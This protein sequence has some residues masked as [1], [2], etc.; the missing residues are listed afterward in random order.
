MMKS[1]RGNAAGD[2]IANHLYV[3]G[4][5]FGKALRTAECFDPALSRWKKLPPMQQAREKPILCV[6]NHSLY[7]SGGCIPQQST[8]ETTFIRHQLELCTVERFN[9]SCQC[10]E[11]MP[12]M[13]RPC[14]HDVGAV[15]GVF[16]GS[17]YVFGA[18]NHHNLG[19]LLHS[20]KYTFQVFNTTTYRWTEIMQK[21]FLRAHV[22]AKFTGQHLYVCG[23]VRIQK[24]GLDNPTYEEVV[25]EHSERFDLHSHCWEI[26]PPMHD[27]RAG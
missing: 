13:S 1:A 9:A 19:G 18:S 26:L 23:G 4:G 22:Q 5:S 20:N 10:W 15:S 21:P 7:V 2:V 25:E 14:F 11:M 12:P 17:V 27:V 16:N 3:V 6:H 8:S 24:T